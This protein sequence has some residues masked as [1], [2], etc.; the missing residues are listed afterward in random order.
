MPHHLYR[1]MAQ[2]QRPIVDDACAGLVRR[3][4]ASLV[5]LALAGT[6]FA[7]AASCGGSSGSSLDSPPTPPPTPVPSPQITAGAP[8]SGAV[9]V[10]RAVL[11][12]HAGEG[13]LPEAQRI[14][15]SPGSSIREL[16]R[17]R[18]GQGQSLERRGRF[19]RPVT[20]RRTRP[21]SSPSTCGSSRQ[22]SSPLGEVP[23]R[24]CSSSASC[25]C[26]TA[27]GGWSRAAPARDVPPDDGRG[28]RPPAR[29]A[30]AARAMPAA[31]KR[32]GR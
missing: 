31:R 25:A 21:S 27:A 5:L 28:Q 30:H 29:E 24:T 8:P 32:P 13:R 9:D 19:C 20:G 6:L 17:H 14:L 22:A 12:R 11:G 10:V 3:R 4:V 23:A 15:T 1:S 7:G 26:P 18:R 2:H 16:D